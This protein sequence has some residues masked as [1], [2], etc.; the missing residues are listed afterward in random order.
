MS[1]WENPVNIFLID[2]GY[3]MKVIIHLQTKKNQLV[4]VQSTHRSPRMSKAILIKEN[5]VRGGY[6]SLDLKT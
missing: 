2:I 4:Y 5:K 6:T 3:R 1:P